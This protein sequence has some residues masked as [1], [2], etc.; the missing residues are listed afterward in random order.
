MA[1]RNW[2]SNPARRAEFH[3]SVGPRMAFLGIGTSKVVKKSFLI[4][5]SNDFDAV[6]DGLDE[7]FDDTGKVKSDTYRLHRW[8]RRWLTQVPV[9][10]NLSVT[11]MTWVSV[12]APESVCNV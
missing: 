3:S 7:M 6:A 9:G 11:S 8:D 1:A 4:V 5:I 12:Y 2:L 10:G